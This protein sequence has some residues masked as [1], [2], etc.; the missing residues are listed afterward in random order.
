MSMIFW[1][2]DVQRNVEGKNVKKSDPIFSEQ[3]L[4]NEKTYILSHFFR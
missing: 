3:K 4:Q 2:K 1:A